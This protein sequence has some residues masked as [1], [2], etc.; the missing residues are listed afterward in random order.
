[1]QPTFLSPAVRHEPCSLAP[2]AMAP[3]TLHVSVHY[4]QPISMIQDLLDG[5]QPGEHTSPAGGCTCQDPKTEDQQS[6]LCCGRRKGKDVGKTWNDLMSQ[7]IRD[8]T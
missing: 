3:H 2:S 1:M 8:K 6:F 4:T 7:L 5:C